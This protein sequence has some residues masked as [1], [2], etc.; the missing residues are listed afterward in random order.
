MIVNAD[1]FQANIVKRKSDMCNQYT[2]K[3][4]GNQ[5]TSEKSVKLLVINTDNKLSFDKHV[6]SLCKKASN[7]LNARS[8]SHS[9][10]GLKEKEVLINSFVYVNFNYFPLI[11]HFCSAKSVRKIE[12]IQ[13]RAL[14]ILCNDFDID[15]KTLLDK[16]DRYTTGVKRLRTLGLEVFKTLNNIN[17]AF[18]KEI[19]HRTKWL[20]HRLNNIQVMFIKH[21]N[22]VINV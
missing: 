5:V 9:Y 22:M 13:T 7:Q 6:S 12:Q 2:L 16:S 14:R 18:M 21:S 8:R 19:F 10:L 4:D 11:W 1:I 3:I 17:P 20:T 15:Y